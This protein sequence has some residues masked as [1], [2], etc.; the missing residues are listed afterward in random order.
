MLR[1]AMQPNQAHVVITAEYFD[2]LALS[3]IHAQAKSF[4]LLRTFRSLFITR[5]IYDLLHV[6]DMNHPRPT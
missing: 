6:P 1:R 5:Q 4:F 2:N 3:F